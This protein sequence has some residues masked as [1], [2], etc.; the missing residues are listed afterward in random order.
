D[1]M[2]N[3]GAILGG[4]ELL[5]DPTSSWKAKWAA[6]HTVGHELAHQWFGD[7]VTCAWWDDIW[8]NESFA[9]LM[10]DRLGDWFP[11]W[12]DEDVYLS[13]RNNALASDGLTSA[14]RIR[15]PIKDTGGIFTAFDGIT[16]QKGASLLRMVEHHIG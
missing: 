9:T 14:R 6:V 7:L 16:Y 8:L 13:V 1:G 5:I 15:E 12:S 2:E 4:P 11:P 10:E 3:A